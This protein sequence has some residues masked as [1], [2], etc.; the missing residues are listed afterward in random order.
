MT[1]PALYA[2]ARRGDLTVPLIGVASSK[3]TLGQLR[4]HA[5]ES[6]RQS[7][8]ITDRPALDHLL[9]LLSYVDG[10][11]NDELTF[12][13]LKIALGAAKRPAFYLAIP[14]SLFPTVIE[15]LG[16]AGLAHQGRVIVEKPFGRDLSSARKL[17]RVAL[18]AFPE[19][20]IFRIDH[21]LAKEA[22]MDILYFRFANAFLE[23]RDGDRFMKPPGVFAT[24]FRTTCSR[25]SRCSRWN[26]P[27][28]GASAPCTAKRLRY[29]RVCVH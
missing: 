23:S 18:A 7:G 17:N 2:M 20:S 8:R 25:S 29:F 14:P 3:W 26:R 10:D 11:Y 16:A 5:T 6:I 15:R 4:K 19:D 24:S 1:F 27:C 9:S 21:Y 13:A 28:I 12:K 22:I